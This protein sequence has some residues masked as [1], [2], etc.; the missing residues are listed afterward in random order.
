M[1]RIS[2]DSAR[3][4]N[5]EQLAK[6]EF[7]AHVLPG[8]EIPKPPLTRTISDNCS[9]AVEG[10]SD[11]SH[12]SRAPE[13][14]VPS[15][16]K[17]HDADDL[18]DVL[19]KARLV[20]LKNVTALR[21]DNKELLQDSNARLDEIARWIGTPDGRGRVVPSQPA[22]DVVQEVRT[23]EADGSLA[24]RRIHLLKQLGAG[25]A[26][27]VYLAQD[28]TG[29][30]FVEKHFGSIP[31]NGS[32]RFGKWLTSVLFS[33]FRQAPLSYRELPEAVV[34]SHLSNQFI[35]SL[36]QARYGYALT[37]SILYTRYDAETGGY[38]QAFEY[39]DGR[40]LR[41][42]DGK[43]PLLGEGGLFFDIMRDWRDFLSN[44]LGFWGLA[45]QVDPANPNSFSNIWVTDNQNVVLLDIVPGLP[46]FLEPR[47][48]WLGLIRGQFPPFGDAIDFCRL[49]SYLSTHDCSSGWHDDLQLL[50]TAVGR[51]QDS[52]PRLFASPAR[53]F[54]VLFNERLHA[55]QRKA[56]LVHLEVKGAISAGQ[57]EAYRNSL[58]ATGRFPRLLR[59]TLLK[60]SPRPIHRA[61]TDGKYALRLVTN[62][63]PTLAR[64]GQ[65]ISARMLSLVAVGWKLLRGTFTVVV[66]RDERLRLC[67][68]EVNQW[69][70]H[71]QQLGRLGSAEA[72]RLR[73]SLKQGE[74]PDITGLFILHMMIGALKQAFLGPSILWLG[75]AAA[76]G[77]LWVAAPAFVSPV[78]RIAATVWVGLWR[79][80][81]IVLLSVVPTVGVL[82]APLYLIRRRTEIGG[83]VIRCIAQKTALGIPGFGERGSMTEILAVAVAE[84]FLIKLGGLLPM[85]LIA[86]LGLLLIGQP[87]LA[88]LTIVMYAAAG[89]L[90]A[91]RIR[92]GTPDGQ[93]WCYGMPTKSSSQ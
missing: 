28:D 89:L 23:F 56:L 68:A 58:E 38:V 60:M 43:L 5:L 54:Q 52:E 45:R 9:R 2:S 53:P 77:Q 83:Y 37:P 91:A 26:G 39:I 30:V 34:A 64:M 20:G 72:E 78:L 65:V 86:G 3:P 74:I 75:A 8:L 80:P 57:A 71:D 18:D 51:W 76:A 84:V 70:E 47:Y 79:R 17:A 81:E 32:K 12:G 4:T 41:P 42:C 61:L 25:L 14:R 92:N 73:E 19:V 27:T 85:L 10:N 88:A 59:H 82:A 29:S 35:V 50:K 46:G 15:L 69:I 63:G 7:S 62:I 90:V 55:L 87:F 36:S 33:F 6:S 66:D 93:V 11:R 44:D 22:L 49:A 21:S 16:L 1:T 67:H 13:S 40:P 48:L 24:I 31:T